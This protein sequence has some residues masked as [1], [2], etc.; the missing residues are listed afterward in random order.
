VFTAE[1]REG[2]T[3]PGDYTRREQ[4]RV[5]ELPNNYI[6]QVRA[7]DI[8]GDNSST[9][10]DLIPHVGKAANPERAYDLQRGYSAIIK[11]IPALS[12]HPRGSVTIVTVIQA[13]EALAQLHEVD[14]S[15][16]GVKPSLRYSNAGEGVILFDVGNCVEVTDATRA[17]LRVDT[18]TFTQYV[19]TLRGVINEDAKCFETFCTA[20]ANPRVTS[21][22][23]AECGRDLVVELQSMSA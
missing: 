17:L 5:A 9:I 12:V 21:A 8:L 2:E 19:R 10:T 11:R 20:I 16:N 18:M 22:M 4:L 3:V 15:L 23:I 6:L 13:A 14:I 7:A 1:W